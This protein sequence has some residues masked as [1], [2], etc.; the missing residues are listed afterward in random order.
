MFVSGSIDLGSRQKKDRYRKMLE[1]IKI[2][3]PSENPS[4]LSQNEEKI[5]LKPI[6]R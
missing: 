4:R 5:K 6:Y 3:E 1:K 2:G